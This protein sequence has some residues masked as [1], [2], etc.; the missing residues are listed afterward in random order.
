MPQGWNQTAGW[1]QATNCATPPPLK[2]KDHFFEVNQK[3]LTRGGKT[4]GHK[5]SPL[6][7][8]AAPV[9]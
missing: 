8:R 7:I 2:P 9:L 6:R 4:G 1:I 5:L 3:K